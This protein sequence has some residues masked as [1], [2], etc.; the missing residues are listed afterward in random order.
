MAELHEALKSL[1]PTAWSDVPLDSL[2]DYLSS[3]FTAGELICNS[4]PPPPNG[5]PFHSSKPHHRRPN[6]AKCAKEMHASAVRPHPPHTAHEGLQSNWGKAMKFSKKDNPHDVALYKM[7]GH[8]R[9]GAWFARRSIHEGMGFGKFKKAMMRELPQSLLVTG[10]PGAGAVRGLGGD[11][12]LESADVEGVG[13]MEVYQLS[14]QMPPPVSPRD[15]VTLFLT[16]DDGLTEKSAA[17]AEEGKKAYVPRHFMIVSKPLNHPDGQ[18]RSSFVRGKYESVE[19]IREI[20]LHQSRAQSTPNLL[21]AQTNDAKQGRERGATIGFAES[22]GPDAK[23]EQRDRDP[24]DGQAEDDDG[25]SDPELNPVEWIMITRSDPGGGI[26]RFLVERGTP[27]AMVADVNKFLDWATSVEDAP[28]AEEASKNGQASSGREVNVDGPSSIAI[29]NG[30]AS[31]EPEPN[32]LRKSMSEP[33]APP[34]ANEGM[35]SHI[36][37]TLEAGLDTYAPTAVS[38]GAHSYLHQADSKSIDTSEPDSDSSSVGSFMSAE[39]MRRLSTARDQLPA[40]SSEALSL[41][42]SETSSITE[43]QNRAKNKEKLNDHE[44]KVL[45]LMKQREKLDQKLAKKR[46]EEETKLKKSQ[47]KD[48][49]ESEKAKEKLEKEMKKTEERHRKEREKLESKQVKEERKIEEKKRKKE[50]QT[51]LSMVSRER[52]ESRSQLESYK[53]EAALLTRQ[54][55]ELQRENTALTNQLGKLGGQEAVKAAQDEAESS[56][57]RASVESRDVVKSGDAAE[58]KKSVDAV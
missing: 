29:A 56:Q 6:A 25:P 26:P 4:V 47:A 36:Q 43:L 1:A 21:S 20:P 23:G 9:H 51:K 19:M 12:R 24:H 13:K 35:L 33:S 54:V 50:E 39:E 34:N 57:A 8:D 16:T 11:H 49:T 48:Q 22:R 18:D 5:T 27:D 32:A 3:R 10:G 42:P 2:A 38:Q 46:D 58:A 55:E 31:K 15:F 45:D 37:H 44:K 40:D 30:T 14:A 53:R 41:A 17:S 28:E 52:D 7:A